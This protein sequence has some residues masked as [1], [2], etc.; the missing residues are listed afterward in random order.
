MKKINDDLNKIFQTILKIKKTSILKK[1]DAKSHP[2]WDSVSHVNLIIA[3]ESKFK[4]N[5]N[6]KDAM[7][8]ISYSKIKKYL[9]E[10]L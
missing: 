1:V 9:K 8:L 2:E 10:R 7:K 5:I 6:D 3:L 4:I